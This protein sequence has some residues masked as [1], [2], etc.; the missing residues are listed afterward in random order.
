MKNSMGE[1]EQWGN[2]RLADCSSPGKCFSR[3]TLGGG[4]AGGG[5]WRDGEGDGGGLRHTERSAYWLSL[6]R[7]T[8]SG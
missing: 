6:V 7:T 4:V 2:G 8:I 1:E 5:G 3:V